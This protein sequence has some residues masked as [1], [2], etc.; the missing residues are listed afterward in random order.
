MQ[1]KPLY[2]VGVI[3]ASADEPKRLPTAE[4]KSQDSLIYE[5]H[6]LRLRPWAPSMGPY[7]W[8]PYIPTINPKPICTFKGP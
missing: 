2:Y 5:N 8:D 1:W 4:D 7:A 6:D 3:C